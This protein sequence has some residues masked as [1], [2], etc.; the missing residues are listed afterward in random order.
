MLDKSI[1]QSN[2]Q[3]A[4][5]ERLV[6]EFAPLI[7]RIAEQIKYKCP[8]GID[9]DDLIQCGVI[10]L[11]Q[12]KNEFQDNMGATFTTYASLKIRYA[13]YQGLRTH[14]GMTRDISQYIK[15]INRVVEDLEKAFKSTKHQNI[16]SEL[17]VT[18]QEYHKMHQQINAQK[19]VSL[20]ALDESNGFIVKDDDNPQ[21]L[22]LNEER[23]THLKESIQRLT[24]REQMIL[25]MYYNE[26]LSLREIGEILGITEARVSQIH[27]QL[28]DK[29][30]PALQ[31]FATT[32]E[33]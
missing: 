7:R 27:S 19:T 1:Y 14:S 28:L 17:A 3:D 4:D 32:L 33:A 20:D 11:L 24:K 6:T 25:A 15:K 12:A 26:F 18:E 21:Q 5:I 22:F 23:T 8:P 31:D 16:M 29:L 30:K 9:I 2:Q 10:G 13:I